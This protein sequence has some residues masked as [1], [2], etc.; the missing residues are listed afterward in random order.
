MKDGHDKMNNAHSHKGNWC[1]CVK[2]S[3]YPHNHIEAKE[4]KECPC[5]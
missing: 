5:C 1:Y 2:C 3:Y 4:C